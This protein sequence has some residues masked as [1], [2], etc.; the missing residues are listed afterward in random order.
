MFLQPHCSWTFNVKPHE[1][2]LNTPLRIIPGLHTYLDLHSTQMTACKVLSDNGQYIGYFLK[3]YRQRIHSL[4]CMV[5]KSMN[6]PKTIYI[7]TSACKYQHPELL[8]PS[9]LPPFLGKTWY[10]KIQ[11]KVQLHQRVHDVFYCTRHC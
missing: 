2:A 5:P 1:P 10:V 4:E 11:P 9:N 8:A 7:A 3:V 6:Y